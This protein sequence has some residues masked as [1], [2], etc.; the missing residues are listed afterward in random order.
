RVD[1]VKHVQLPFWQEFVPAVM[2]HAKDQGIPNFHMFGEVYDSDPAFLSTFTTTGKLPA[3]LDFGFQGNSGAVFSDGGSPEKLEKLFTD[4][5]YYNDHDSQADILLSFIG[6]HDMGRYGFFLNTNLPEASDAEKLQRSIVTHALMY[7]SRGIPV[8]YYGD[9]Q[10][11]T[12]DGNDMAAREDMMPSKVDSFNDNKLLGTDVT[13]AVENFDRSHPIYISLKEFA[14]TYQE[15]KALRR[16]V[17][18]HR[19]ADKESGIYAFSRVDLKEKVEYLL[20]F[21]SSTEPKSVTLVATSEGYS[22]IAGEIQDVVVV[23]GNVTLKVPALD[24][25]IYKANSTIKSSESL[26]VSLKDVKIDERSKNFI[27]VDFDV[28]GAGELTIPMYSVTTEY[29]AVSGEYVL[30]SVDYTY[31][32]RSKIRA[33]AIVH[34]LNGEVRVTVDNL[35]GNVQSTVFSLS[36]Q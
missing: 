22:A 4:D 32:Y 14:Q 36:K 9:E 29:K 23:D 19:H 15:H 8:V 35:A 31:P 2:A 20:A 5:D 28:A 7:F 25:V 21:N 10:G 26:I 3:I 6:N 18:H 30:A 17:H 12:G 33:D 24:Y 16:G 34:G 27:A 11:F 13:T 1:T